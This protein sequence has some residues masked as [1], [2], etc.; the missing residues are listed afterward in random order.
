MTKNIQDTIFEIIK[1]A[2]QSGLPSIRKAEI[3]EEVKKT[4]LAEN[5]IPNYSGVKSKLQCDVDQAL[6]QLHKSKRIKKRGKGWTVN[7]GA[8]PYKPIICNHLIEKEDGYY[9]PVKK[10]YIGDP[11]AQCELLHGSKFTGQGWV[12]GATPMCPGYTSRKSTKVSREFAERAIELKNQK[13]EEAYRYHNPDPRDALSKFY[14]P[15]LIEE[16]A[17]CKQ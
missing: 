9:C 4:P 2:R 1:F 12:K 8:T 7:K 13:R 6:Y 11:K 3:M 15:K 10:A 14:Q 16:E 17:K 5:D